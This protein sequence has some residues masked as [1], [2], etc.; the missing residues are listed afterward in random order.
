MAETTAPDRDPAER[1]S[2]LRELVAHHNERYHSL[3]DPEI[4][5]ADFDA[6][7]RELRAL[8]AE[9]PD[10]ITPDSPTQQVGGAINAS[11]EPVEHA[12]PMMSLD[13]AMDR[14]ELVAWADRVVKGLDGQVPTFVCELKFDG[15]AMSLRYEDGRFVRAATRG[16]GRV[17]EDVTANVATIADVPDTIG[18]ASTPAPAV[19]E[20]RG[21][22]YMSTSAFER[23][24]ER[25]AAA[26]DKPFVNPRNSAAGS[27]RQKDAAKTAERELS[28][29][30]YQL[31]ELRHGDGPVPELH[32]HSDELR[33]IESLGFPVDSH[34]SSVDS[35]DAVAATCL[36]WQE[37]RHDLDFEIDGV[38]VKVDDAKQRE[39]LGFTS[40]APRWAIAYKF[41]PEERTTTLLDIQVSVGRT[42]RATPFAVLDP[43][44]V[45]G[46]TVSMATL[47]NQDQVA[48]KDVRPGDTVIVRKA[49][50]VI[51]EVVGPVITEGV[52]RPEPWVF[53][54]NCPVCDTPLVRPE[55]E[56]DTRCVAPDCPA[57]RNQKIA[58]FASRGAMDIEGLG[59]QMVEKLTDAELIRDPADLYSITVEQLIELDR[60]GQTSAQNLVDEIEKSKTRPLPKFLT[61]L[62]VRHFGPAATKALVA[63]FHTVD[64]IMSKSVEELAAVD[65]VGEV[66]ANTVKTWFEQEAN[67]AY[68]EKF[69]AAGVDFGDPDAA[70]LAA[71]A[72]ASVPQTLEGKAVVV[73][74]TLAAYNREEAGE[75]ITSRGGKNPGSVSKKTFA[76]VVGESAGASKLTKAESLGVPI[77][78][79]AGF[80]H[81][82]ATGELGSDDG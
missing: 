47:H 52:E 1:L 35:I 55:G 23:L 61:A 44:F 80:E 57:Q 26:G 40:R 18:S 82:L 36:H 31:G 50:D 24:N 9:H 62:G 49:G 69:R 21:E 56:A 34:S 17:G 71:E 30:S 28:F 13:N 33:Y 46:S 75:A 63:E 48:V 11:F 39:L 12:V 7:A 8:E 4:S 81:L 76:L 70:R 41:P 16:D 59:E 60:I 42:G 37:H 77:I 3:D 38:V 32:S 73:T 22:V 45:G 19:I 54:T 5:D 78:D 67:R 27:L 20:V 74:G 43:V 68:I 79:E 58:Y 10:L 51:P 64:E 53:P 15:L 6:L 2:E 29:W 14:D 65:G 66:I 72:K 25:A